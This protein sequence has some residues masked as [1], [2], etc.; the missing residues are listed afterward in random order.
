MR[1]R[2]LLVEDATDIREVFK[3]LLEAEGAEVVAPGSGREGA[4]LAAR[5]DFDIVLTDLGLPDISGEMVIRHVLRHARRRPRVVVLT[6]YD[7]P[8]TSRALEAGADVVLTKPVLWAS[9]VDEL[10]VAA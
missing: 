8:F 7:E 10:S 9:L 2:I 3:M 5:G 4:E 6:G 1:A